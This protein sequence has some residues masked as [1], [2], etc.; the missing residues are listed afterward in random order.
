[1]RLSGLFRVPFAIVCDINSSR[2]VV[3]AERARSD[4]FALHVLLVATNSAMEYMLWLIVCVCVFLR[5][6]RECANTS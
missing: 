6:H 5:L 2:L 1:M 3:A 4:V